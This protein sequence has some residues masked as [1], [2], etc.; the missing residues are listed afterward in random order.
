MKIPIVDKQDNIITYKERE[1]VLPEDIQRISATW[2]FSDKKE[3]LVQQRS[4]LKKHSP[5]KWSPSAA[6]T[7]EEGETYESNAKKELEEELGLKGA[8]LKPIKKIFYEINDTRRYCFIYFTFSNF[9]IDKFVLQ[10]KEVEQ[11]RWV[12]L[13]DLLEWYR[14]SPE[15]FTY[16]TR[17]AI[18]PIKNYFNDSQS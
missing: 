15:E 1:E 13:G 16:S 6:G 10:K 4:F 17:F 12:G 3:V 7:V 9:S 2:V 11:I 18:D 8:K 14:K 5:G